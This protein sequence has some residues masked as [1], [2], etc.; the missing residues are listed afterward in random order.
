MVVLAVFL[1]VE[2]INLTTCDKTFHEGGGVLSGQSTSRVTFVQDRVI[3]SKYPI[4]IINKVSPV[5]L[6][7]VLR[8]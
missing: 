6:F 4:S 7:K 8:I 5:S 3:Q 2:S 1:R